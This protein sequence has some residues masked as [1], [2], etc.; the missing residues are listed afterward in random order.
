MRQYR[1][2]QTAAP[3]V[4]S[5]AIDTHRFGIVMTASI[6]LFSALA[7]G[8]L[9]SVEEEGRAHAIARGESN[10]ATVLAASSARPM[11]GRDAAQ[12]DRVWSWRDSAD[13]DDAVPAEAMRARSTERNA[14]FAGIEAGER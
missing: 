2:N 6:A 13:A 8:N 3:S 7:I 9:I 12:N 10:P 5:D 14:E 4:A 11:R 1:P